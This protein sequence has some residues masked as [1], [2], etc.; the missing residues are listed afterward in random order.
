M[1]VLNINECSINDLCKL[2]RIGMVIAS[3]IIIERNNK[4]FESKQ[5]LIRRVKGITY[6]ILDD[7]NKGLFILF[8]FPS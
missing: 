1:N 2:N 6:N 3:R 5:D 4:L 7:K 8:V